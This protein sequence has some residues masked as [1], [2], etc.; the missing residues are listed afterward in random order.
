MKI[1]TKNIVINCF[2]HTIKQSNMAIINIWI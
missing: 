2:K 1:L